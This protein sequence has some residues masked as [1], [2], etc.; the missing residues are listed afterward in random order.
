MVLRDSYTTACGGRLVVPRKTREHLLAHPDVVGLLDEVTGLI[1]LPSDGSFLA[2]EVNLGRVLGRSG[3]VATTPIS[4]NESTLFAQRVAREKP[5]RVVVGMEGP[6]TSL[7][8]LLA[9]ASREPGR[10]YVLITAWRGPIAPKEPW[11]KT[12]GSEGEKAVALKFWCHNA[13]VYDP[14]VMGE[15]FES[16]WEE[17]LRT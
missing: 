5:T 6:K 10:T 16:T 2:T 13:L 4:M 9:F 3:C 17:V 8:A 14:A 1:Q 12:L 7:V 15:P 11:D